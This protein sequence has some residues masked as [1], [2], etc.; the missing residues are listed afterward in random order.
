[1]AEGRD[2]LVK[3]KAV[4]VNP[5]DTK[6]G[7]QRAPAEGEV[8]VLGWDA[9]GL[10]AAVGA[11]VTLFKPGDKVWYAGAITRPGTN[12]QCHL[13]DDRLT[14]PT[15]RPATRARVTR[16]GAHHVIDHGQPLAEEIRRLGLPPAHDVASLNESARHVDDI[17]ALRAPQGKL[18]LIGD[19]AGST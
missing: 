16:L 13:V 11:G 5:V 18:A 15:S 12:S 8:G 6:I 7:Q 19:P 14:G 3:V 2:P 4:S 10:V 9:A 17:V 1:M